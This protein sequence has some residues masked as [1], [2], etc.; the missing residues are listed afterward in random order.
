M[1]KGGISQRRTPEAKQR[2]LDQMRAATNISELSRQTGIPRR[3]L[4]SWRDK[5]Q[6]S[7]ASGQQKPKTKQQELEQELARTKQAL[8]ERVLDLD[9]FRTALQRIWAQRQPS[10]A[11]VASSSTTKSAR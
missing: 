10:G 7:Q 9:F 5:Q 6:G 8:A 1:K 2:A 4:Y 11:P 3:T